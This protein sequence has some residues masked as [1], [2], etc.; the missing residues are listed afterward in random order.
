VVACSSSRDA[1][2]G[3]D[4]PA[5]AAPNHRRRR[6]APPIKTLNIRRSSYTAGDTD[7]AWTRITPWRALLAAALD[8]PPYEDIETVT[9]TGAG[10]NPS[11][12]LLAGWLR[13]RLRVPVR[14]RASGTGGGISSVVLARRS[15]PVELFRSNGKVGTL[16]QPGQ[17]DRQV[18]LKRRSLRDCLAE[19][20]RRLDP[21][22]IYH[23]ALQ[24]L[25]EVHG[26]TA[27]I[28]PRTNSA[29]ASSKTRSA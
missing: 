6:G 21:D 2:P 12:D 23:A 16:R 14:R 19:E 9:V 8:L 7:L 27:T 28:S 3:S 10:D 22:D 5:G 17:P 26:W 15:G 1:C 11:T 24:A 25:T 13:S 29:K 18:P 4:W 20:L